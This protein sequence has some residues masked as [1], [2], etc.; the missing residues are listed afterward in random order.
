MIYSTRQEEVTHIP[1]RS[2]NRLR[3]E[4]TQ[5]RSILHNGERNTQKMQFNGGSVVAIAVA[6]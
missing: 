5:A 6:I 2:Y 4:L 1:C 3:H